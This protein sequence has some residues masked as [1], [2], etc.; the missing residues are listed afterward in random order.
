MAQLQLNALSADTNI[1]GLS[2]AVGQGDGGSMAAQIKAPTIIYASRTHSQ[3][4]QVVQVT[5]V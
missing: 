4:S 1:A 2:S 3:L 5:I